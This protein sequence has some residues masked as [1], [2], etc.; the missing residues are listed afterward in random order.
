[1]PD[2]PD[3]FRRN[4]LWS[5]RNARN[6]QVQ[7]LA[8]FVGRCALKRLFHVSENAHFDFLRHRSTSRVLLDLPDPFP[9]LLALL[10]AGIF[11]FV[12]VGKISK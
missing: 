1:L 2:V 8:T 4:R 3:L 5:R 6:A 9:N 7:G 12:L 11:L 10:F